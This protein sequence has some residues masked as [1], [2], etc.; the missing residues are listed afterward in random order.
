MWLQFDKEKKSK[1]LGG[2]AQNLCKTLGGAK[3]VKL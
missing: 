3:F 2:K 1:S